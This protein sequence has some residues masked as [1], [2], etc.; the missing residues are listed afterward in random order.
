M[1][2][3]GAGPAGLAAA[4]ALNDQGVTDI[5]VIDRDDAPG[6]LPRFCPHPGFG[7]EY[8]H[9]PLTGPS[10]VARLLGNLQRRSV[11]IETATTLVSLREG[12]LAEVVGPRMGLRLVRPRAVVLATGIRES[13][14]G[15]LLVP[16][17]RAERGILTTGQ[18][19]QM[20][21][22]RVPVHDQLKTLV[23]VGTE[24]VAFSSILTARHLRMSVRAIVGEEDRIL[25]Y[26]ISGWLARA[27]GIEIVTGARVRSIETRNGCVR[28]VSIEDARGIREIACGAVLFS[29]NWI[30]EIGALYGAPIAIDPG[31]RGPAVDQAM[32]T[33]CRGVFAAGNVLHGVE[34]SGWCA[35]E[36]ARAGALVARFLRGEI[37][38]P[39]GRHTISHSPDIDYFVPQRWDDRLTDIPLQSCIPATLR[40][41]R[42]L[43][44]HRLVLQQGDIELPASG[45]RTF[46]RKR[47]SPIDLRRIGLLR[48]GQLAFRVGGVA[49]DSQSAV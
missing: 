2:I 47:R 43:H 30:P 15:N 23:V 12:P 48:D 42:D 31:T 34:S 24:H 28:G 8:F 33:S 26:P 14:R 27:F 18:L 35:I 49:P 11:R 7:L 13:N 9:W 36:G 5:I 25:S 16:G 41:A 10:F 22:R 19:Q 32:R 21:A 39:Q 1:L 37:Q 17:G 20:L 44:G 45:K 29:G 38:G 3:V 40:V 46:L 4:A 6:G